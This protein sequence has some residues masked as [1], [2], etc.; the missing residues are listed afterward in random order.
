MYRYRTAWRDV[1]RIVIIIINL[2]QINNSLTLMIPIQWPEIWLDFKEYFEWADLDIMSLSGTT[3]VEGVNFYFTFA[4]M[5]SVPYIIIMLA[6]LFFLYQKMTLNYHMK[7]MPLKEREQHREHAFLEAFLIGDKDGDGL[8][9]PHELAVLLNHELHLDT[10]KHG[11]FK[12]D[13]THALQIIRKIA[14]DQSAMEMPLMMFLGAMDRN[15]LNKAVNEVCDLPIHHQDSGQDA[16][17]KFIVERGLFASSFMIATH[18]LLLAHSPVSKKVFIF[19]LCRNI[20]GRSFIRSDYSIECY[21]SGWNSFQPAVMFVLIT[22]TVGFPMVLVLMLY[23]NRNRLYKREIYAKMGFLYER[24]V[25]G[26]EWWE[27]HGECCSSI[28]IKLCS[29]VKFL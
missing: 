23:V 20:G 6:L 5:G 1:M 15:I 25:R 4:A 29:F 22:F 9:T 18:M 12:I 13:T 16:M 19:Y 17:L 24:Y 10:F 8:M 3:C 28:E 14:N 26:S 21:E 2:N 7:H 27:I 11:H